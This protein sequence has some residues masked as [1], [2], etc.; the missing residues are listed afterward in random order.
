MRTSRSRVIIRHIFVLS[1]LILLG[2]AASGYRRAKEVGATTNEGLPS[3][4]G[5][6]AITHMKERG[7]YASLGEA[8][9][10]ARA[11]AL[12]L[13]TGVDPMLTSPTRLEAGDGKKG[14]LFGSA[15]AI[16]GD[17]AIVGAPRNDIN[18]DADQGAAYIFVRSGG[19]WTQEARLKAPLGAVGDFFGRAVAISGDTAIVGAYLDDTVA[20]VNQGVVYVFT[21]SAGVW[22]QQ[23]KLKADDGGANDFFGLSVAIYGDTAIIGAYLNDTGPN[24]NQGAAYVFNRSGGTWTQTQKLNAS[25]A[26]AGDL[27]GFSVALDAETAVIGACGK[28]EGGA[29]NAGAAYVFNRSGGTWTERQKLSPPNLEQDDFFGAAVA[30]SGDTALIGAFG[31]D[32]GANADQGAAHVFVRS[33][34]VWTR[35]QRLTAVDGSAS[36][37]FGSAVALSGDT[38]VIG[39]FGKDFD[40]EDQG[41]AYVFSRSGTTWSQQ[42]R[43]FASDGE[44]GDNFGAAVAISGDTMLAGAPFDDV[45][46]NADQGSAHVFQICQGLAQQQ[47]FTVNNGEAYEYFGASVAISGDT[48]VVGAPMDDVG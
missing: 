23:D 36:D 18:V 16:S 35:Q 22:T 25:D 33:G 19:N 47:K 44:A 9:K 24:V 17:T 26:A 15:V 46:G 40:G 39:A 34:T 27:F 28:H 12:A 31:D 30:V 14:D 13:P 10:A 45:G 37:Q 43:L 21:R 5:E 8:V 3:L 32:I 42:P 4:R 41:A 20:N 48:A 29:A 2:L 7:L 6:E 1:L 11:N 38:A